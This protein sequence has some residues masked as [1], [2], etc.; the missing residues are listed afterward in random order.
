MAVERVRIVRL[1]HMVYA[2]RDLE[3]IAKF[4]IDFGFELEHETA[5]AL[6]YRGYGEQPYLYVVRKA[7]EPAF[8]GGCWLVES[9]ADLERAAR[10]AG[11]TS[12]ATVDAPGGG[13]E[14]VVKECVTRHMLAISLIVQP[15]WV[16]DAAHLRPKDAHARSAR[17]CAASQRRRSKAPRGRVHPLSWPQTCEDPQA[18]SVARA[19][20]IADASGHYGFGCRDFEETVSW[21]TVRR[22]SFAAADATV[23]F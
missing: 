11:A 4:L 21:Y 20:A 19:D 8:L 13:E 10:I 3:A 1:A 5:D 7:D 16:P 23:A 18:R 17:S 14:V 6:Y 15:E 2:H 22:T 12:I 9:R